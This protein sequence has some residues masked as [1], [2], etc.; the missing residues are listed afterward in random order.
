MYESREAGS[1]ECR[2]AWLRGA[3][4]RAAVVLW[5]AASGWV[6][7]I[8]AQ[9]AATAAD[10]EEQSA[11][12]G[13]ELFNLDLLD[14]RDGFAIPPDSRFLPGET[15]HL[16][17]QIRGYEVGEEDRVRLR[18]QVEALD[19]EGRR[20]DSTEGGQIDTELA[21]QDENW[22]P[23]VRY[24]PRIPY[25]A[26]GGTYAIRISVEDELAGKSVGTEVPFEVDGE[27][28]LTAGS[29]T[30][31]NFHFSNAENGDKLD[32][33]VFGPG[34]PIWAAFFITGYETR[35]DN[36]YDVESD[37]WVLDAKGQRMFA[38][39]SSGDEGSPFYPRL[40]LPARL[41]MDLEQDIPPGNYTVVLHVRDGVSGSD[42]T[43][44]YGFKIR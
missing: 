6:A 17:F 42:A 43:E 23:I 9:P 3:I 5:G 26:G 35:H 25:H 7:P 34:E 1:R 14:S 22:M 38:F 20:F 21:P 33:P 18:Y 40:W 12:S 37:A 4:C 2:A 28:L 13:L 32:E 19:P 29:L 31:R 27:R 16:Y 8:A 36:S 41:R 39:E 10:A 15:V 44:R 30:V 24:S 11:E